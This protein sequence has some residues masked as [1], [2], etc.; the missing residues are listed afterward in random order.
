MHS[1]E[2]SFVLPTRHRPQF[3]AQ[4]LETFRQQHDGECELI[5]C[6]NWTD[7]SLSAEAVVHEAALERVHYVRPPEPLSMV[8][9]WQYAIGHARGTYV[10]MLT[11]KIFLIPGAVARIRAGLQHAGEPEMLCWT[12]DFHRSR[13]FPDYFGAGV[14]TMV[15]AHEPGDGLTTPFAPA[16]VLDE[17]GR[18]A[19]TRGEQSRSLYCRGKISFGVYHRDLLQRLERRFGAIFRDISPDYTSM[20]LGLAEARSGADLASSAVVSI[21]TDLSN[22]QH[23]STN[24]RSALAYLQSLA[25]G[26]V[27]ELMADMLIPGVYASQANTVARDYR[28]MMRLFGLGFAFDPVHWAVHTLEDLVTPARTWSTP[29]ARDEQMQRVY[30]WIATLPAAEQQR[31]FAVFEARAT[32]RAQGPITQ[33]RPG[34]QLEWATPSLADALRRRAAWSAGAAT[35]PCLTATAR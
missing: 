23:T 21:V 20:V 10:G 27:D 31:L 4:A 1:P 18:A 25:S 33:Q 24:D 22:G 5:V 26:T 7:P 19:F 11:D 14:Y 32:Q 15:Q 30:Q 34:E 13:A 8:D 2:F 17:R 28:H 3:V 6:D 9:N 16:A 29:A 12:T 35:A